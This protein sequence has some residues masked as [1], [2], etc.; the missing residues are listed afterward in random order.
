[1]KIRDSTLYNCWCPI[2]FHGL[3]CDYKYVERK[4]QQ[5]KESFSDGYHHLAATLTLNSQL[6]PITAKKY[7]KIDVDFKF[8][9]HHH[10]DV[11]ARLIIR[12]N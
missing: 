8:L 1:M 6:K 12:I 4:Y 3:R 9:P 5:T 2:G 11:A 10:D 7:G